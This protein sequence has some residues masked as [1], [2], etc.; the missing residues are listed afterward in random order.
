MD[1]LSRL[2]EAAKA[3]R[4][5]AYAPYSRFRVGAALMTESGAVFAGCNVENAAFPAGLCAEA[6][7]IAAMAVAGERR[8]TDIVVVGGGAGAVAPCGTCRQRLFEFAAPDARVH[9]ADREG[10]VDASPLADL[11]PRAFGP[12]D[13]NDKTEAGLKP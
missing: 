2:F 8:I 3:A 11:L 7:A 4:E 9:F 5:N 12:R 1:A 10:I 6:G 13:L